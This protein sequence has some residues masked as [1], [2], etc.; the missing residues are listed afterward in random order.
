MAG[1]SASSDEL[2]SRQLAL[3]LAPPTDDDVAA[4]YASLLAPGRPGHGDVLVK[5]SATY[6][7]RGLFAA[8][9]FAEG[10]R[11]LC[12]P[13]LVGIQQESNREDAAVCAQCFRYVGS[14]ERQIA[15]RLL[16]DSHRK[17]CEGVVER[18]VLEEL[19]QGTRTLPNSSHFPL[20]ECF[21]CHGGCDRN[22]Y[23]S[24]AC[25]SNAWSR[26]ERHLC[27]GPCG[28]SGRGLA[29]TAFVNHAKETNDIFPLAARVLLETAYAAENKRNNRVRL[30]ASGTSG[31][32]SAGTTHSSEIEPAMNP[33]DDDVSYADQ[34]L[35]D[36]WRP[37]AVAHKGVWWETVAKPA[38]VP[39]GAGEDEF[40][41]SMRD[42]AAESLNLLRATLAL[43][44]ANVLDR[45]PG[46][47]TIEVYAVV[48]G[49]FELNN[50]E[51]AVA[52]PVEDYFLAADETFPEDSPER[53]VT[54]PLLDALDVRYCVPCEGT[55]FF[56]LQSQLNS[57][58]DPNVTPLKDDGDVDGSCVLVAKRAVKK[59]E[60]L[61]MCYVDE[62][63][64]V[65]ER[66]AE[67]ADYGFEC[68]CERCERESA[69]LGQARRGGKT[70]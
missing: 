29:A 51:V 60:E 3:L 55:G 52:S 36:A 56:A 7:G 37:Y 28:G 50:L 70:K 18:R 15:T 24:D 1:A 26:H 39:E 6:R 48:I 22:S 14:I 40:R 33:D 23:C 41:A 54:D 16:R 12:E 64:D 35:V 42:I 43:S 38:D 68:A 21:E 63:A 10:E 46:L 19:A 53:L 4:Y 61:T 49:M 11:V 62:D 47:F 69:G 65:R 20:P 17:A 9:D 66:R 27:V 13:P 25:A 31:A 2:A 57:D 45:Y 32:P 34:C 59:G 5:P 67:L 30:A 8:R 44:D 58:C